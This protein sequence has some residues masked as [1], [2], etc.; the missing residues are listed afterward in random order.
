[1]PLIAKEKSGS[2]IEP[3]EPGV[4]VGVCYGLID[5]GT[6]ENKVF[7]GE[8]HKLLIQW[9]LPDCRG[10]FERDGQK[11]NLP[12]AI[13]KRYTLSLSKKANLRKDLESWRG[14]KFTD[15]E[16]QGFDVKA[17]LGTSCQLQIAHQTG[18]DGRTF[19]N[20]VAIMALPKGTPRPNKTEN[21]TVFYAFEEA[22][23]KPDLPDVPEWVQNII[24]ES[25]E[26]RA[27]MIGSPAPTGAAPDSEPETD[28]DDNI[29][30]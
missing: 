1:M 22:G 3:I 23:E 19:A 10:E 29:L 18:K 12:R 9:E 6:H 20:I 30:F 28:E 14:R 17:I 13:S 26:W 16:L 15:D 25:K 4:Y 21:P 2:N 27:M 5:L 8:D 11:V 24:T 7:G